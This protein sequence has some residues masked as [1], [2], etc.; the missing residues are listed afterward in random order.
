MSKG[1]PMSLPFYKKVPPSAYFL[2]WD[3]WEEDGKDGVSWRQ[4]IDAETKPVQT[5]RCK[6][7]LWSCKDESSHNPLNLK[8]WS[9]STVINYAIIILRNPINITVL[10]VYH[11]PNNHNFKGIKICPQIVSIEI[12]WYLHRVWCGFHIDILGLFVI[13]SGCSWCLASWSQS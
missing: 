5:N 7:T 13:R 8:Y 9:S 11:R 1:T 4:W 2:A 3:G 6:K 12:R 10:I